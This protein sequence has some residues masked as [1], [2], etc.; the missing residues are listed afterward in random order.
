MSWGKKLQPLIIEQA[1]EDLQPRGPPERRR[2]L[3]APRAPRLHRDA[4]IICPDRGPGAIETKCVFDYRGLDGGLERR[5]AAAPPRRDPASSQQMYV[6]DGETPYQWGVIAAVGRR[7]GALF[8]AQA[9]PELFDRC[10]PRP[11]AS[12]PR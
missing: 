10:T 8:R 3:C 2:H 1:A 5:Q 6:G 9:D 12:S 7:R 4:T 11:N